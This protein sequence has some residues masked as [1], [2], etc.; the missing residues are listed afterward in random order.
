MDYIAA[1]Q[2]CAEGLEIS[3]PIERIIFVLGVD[4]GG[5]KL[6][7]GVSMIIRQAEGIFSHH[8]TR[9]DYGEVNDRIARFAMRGYS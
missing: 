3:P 5:K 6:A 9:R 4:Y 8:P 1:V 7:H 2:S